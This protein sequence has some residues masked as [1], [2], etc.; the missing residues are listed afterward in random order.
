MDP[1][2]HPGMYQPQELWNSQPYL[3]IGTPNYY[4]Y[5][6]V[7]HG[8]GVQPMGGKSNDQSDNEQGESEA[9]WYL[10]LAILEMIW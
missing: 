4:S 2:T 8:T 10:V 5:P 1:H 6:R 9:S 7:S 3:F